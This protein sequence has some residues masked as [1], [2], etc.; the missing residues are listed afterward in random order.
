LKVVVEGE[1]EGS[2]A[3]I[4]TVTSTIFVE[5]N[6]LGVDEPELTKYFL[7]G[8]P[9]IEMVPSLTAFGEKAFFMGRETYSFSKTL[10]I[11]A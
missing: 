7:L 2:I 8:T 9:V 6:I 3:P 5:S 11:K 4:N 1:I 10:E